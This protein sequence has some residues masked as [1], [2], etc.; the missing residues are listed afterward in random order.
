MIFRA[1]KFAIKSVLLLIL[2]AVGIGLYYLIPRPI[3]YDIVFDR[4]G[5]VRPGD[6]VRL[7]EYEIGRVHRVEILEDGRTKVT[8]SIDRKF[9][10]KVRSNSTALLDRST[11]GERGKTVNVH[12]LDSSSPPISPGSEVE[13][14]DSVMELQLKL[15]REKSREWFVAL[16]RQLDEIMDKLSQLRG[17]EDFQQ[18]H[19]RASAL[20]ESMN[21]WARDHYVEIQEQYPGAMEH[22]RRAYD[23][24]REI[25]DESLS[26]ILKKLM[27]M[28]ATPTPTPTT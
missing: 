20:A 22:L 18:L 2:L 28:F 4:A 9:Q 12:N 19:Q 11:G 26:E 3:R 14:T 8:V 21:E 23:R 16:S 25:G 6:P 27:E 10:D 1:F 15:A 7:G 13:G 17:S 5:G 24:A